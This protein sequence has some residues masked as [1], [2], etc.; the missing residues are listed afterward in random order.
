MSKTMMAYNGNGGEMGMM[1]LETAQERFAVAVVENG[2][3]TVTTMDELTSD[4]VH[5]VGHD[6]S[7]DIRTIVEQAVSDGVTSAREI[8]AI[9]REARAEW[10]AEQKR[11][12]AQ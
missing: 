9:V 3:I 6:G 8:A 5:L 4:V 12:R 7:S 10:A 2:C 11:E 1:T